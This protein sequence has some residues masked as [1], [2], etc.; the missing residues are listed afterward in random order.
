MRSPSPSRALTAALIAQT[1]VSLTEQGLPT[2]TGFI[3][4]DLALSATAAGALVA[5]IP[6]GRILGSYAGGRTVDHI[7]ERT[8]LV[9]GATAVGLLVVLAGLAPL[10]ALV[11]LLLAVGAFASTATPA[12]AKLVLLSFPSHHRGTAMG[13]RQAGVPLGGLL[14]ALAL[15][16][17][18]GA[19]SWRTA[20]VVGGALTIVGGA[21]ALAAGGIESRAQHPV[22]AA[23]RRST[24]VGRG[25]LHDRDLLLLTV[26]GVMLVSGQY[27][28][29]AFLPIYLHQD[30]QLALT[31][32]TLLVAIA[33]GGAIN[34]RLVWGIVSDRVFHGRRRPL[35]FIITL[36]G[37]AT[38]LVLGALPTGTPLVVY[39]IAAF[40]GGTS[41]IGWQG[42]FIVSIGELAGPQRAGTATGLALTFI[43]VGIAAAPPICGLIADV[44]GGFQAMW[45]ALAILVGLALVPAMLVHE[46]ATTRAESLS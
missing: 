9:A 13:L 5:A 30:T 41:V 1:A 2:V 31:T 22:N 44:A 29:I 27:V 7:G 43:S 4:Q 46:P 24:R 19:W 16:W 15:P 14:A 34:G 20:L 8:V 17:L 12:G 45:M 32:A 28:L 11:L 18:S 33:Q 35:L 42:I 23:A 37:C 40:L 25:L 36:V 10:G 38:F 21:A 6:A 3:K 26:W 39:G